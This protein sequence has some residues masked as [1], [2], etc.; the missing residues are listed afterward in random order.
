MIN[1]SYLLAAIPPIPYESDNNM[2]PV[3]R[4]P[5]EILDFILLCSLKSS[6]IL[7]IKNEIMIKAKQKLIIGSFL[8]FCVLLN[9]LIN[10]SN[11]YPIKNKSYPQLKMISANLALP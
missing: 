4:T 11:I 10:I 9:A 5:I 1:L 7:N 3:I 6:T 8:M 2:D